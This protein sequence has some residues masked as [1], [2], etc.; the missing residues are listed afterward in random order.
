MKLSETMFRGGN[1]GIRLADDRRWRSEVATYLKQHP[2]ASTFD[3][4]MEC[5]LSNKQARRY[6]HA[7]RQSTKT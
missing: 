6:A 1:S 2:T 4:A 3:I 7:V 5:H